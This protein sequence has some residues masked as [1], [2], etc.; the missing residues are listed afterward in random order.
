MGPP[1][2]NDTVDQLTAALTAALAAGTR[3]AFTALLTDDVR[4]GGERR[5]GGHE[6]TTRVQAGDHFAGLIATGI[7][8]SID[9]IDKPEISNDG[10]S[11][12]ARMTVAAPDPDETHEVRVRLTVRDG[13][14]ADICI[15]DDPPLVEVLYFDGCPHYELLLPRLDELLADNGIAA[16]VTLSRIDTSEQAEA[17]QFRGSPSVRVNGRDI[18]P[19]T[20][21]K[22]LRNTEEIPPH[23]GMQCRLY[24]T[25]NGTTGIPPDQWILDAIVDN[26]THEA[27]VTAIHDGDQCTLQHLLAE[28]TELASLH[29]PRREGRTLLHVATDWPGHF[30][31]VSAT[32]AA[33]IAFGAD[34]D[35]RFPGEHREAPLHWAASSDDIAAIDA[36][37]DAGADI[38]ARGAVIA[39]GTPLSDATAFGQW[40][41]ARRLVERGA[42]TTLFDAA[43][44]GLVAVVDHHL[45]TE[46]PTR[47]NI[48]SSFW[49][50]CHGGQI[51]TATV[52][53]DLGADIDWVGYDGLT[54]LDAA[55]RSERHDVVRW[56]E[57]RASAAVHPAN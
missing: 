24:Y 14:I 42:A 16:A 8:L 28:H 38:D 35:C 12:T 37:L 46:S 34:P 17:R 22:S 1:H 30:P 56:L 15:M 53:L 21:P 31:N 36:L 40:N 27:A 3:E 10:H 43:A 5:G 11:I 29:L 57:E 41:A 47:E 32:I 33:L 6:C 13:L 49:G 2:G 48:T 52:L 4:W 51:T 19:V 54:P 25:A 26:P 20:S 39:D 45:R 23:Y 9:H 44:L 18:E 50:A 7:T 55:R